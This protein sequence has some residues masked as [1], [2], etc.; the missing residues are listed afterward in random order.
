LSK[1]IIKDKIE[2]NMEDI[3]LYSEIEH[4]IIAWNIDGTKTAGYLTREIMG[5]INQRKLYKEQQELLESAYYNFIYNPYYKAKSFPDFMSSQAGQL[6]VC[7]T[8]EEFVNR[9]KTDNE[10]SERWGLKIE[11]RELSLVERMDLSREKRRYSWTWQNWSVEE[12]EWRMNN[13]LNFINSFNNIGVPTKLI[14]I[15]YNDKT[16]ERYE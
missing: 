11:E 2:S 13:D 3:K 1:N 15:S 9:C 12:M 7:P 10:F 16:I 4:L 8:M 14:I 6:V 5:L